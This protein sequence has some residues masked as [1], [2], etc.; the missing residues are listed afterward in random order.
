MAAK[1]VLLNMQAG[2]VTAHCKDQGKLNLTMS[3][4]YAAVNLFKLYIA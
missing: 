3:K 4:V 1:T 2:T